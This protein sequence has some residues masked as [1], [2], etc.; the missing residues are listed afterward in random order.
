VSRGFACAAYGDDLPD[1]L[2]D[3]C[4]FEGAIGRKCWTRGECESRMGEERQR[5]FQRINEL[6]AK[7][8]P[9][10]AFL[11]DEFSSPDQLLN[12]DESPD[13]PSR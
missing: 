3:L 4:F 9:D 11:A 12:A 7:G 5:V 8:D 2:G 13:E 1:A 6:A 10:M